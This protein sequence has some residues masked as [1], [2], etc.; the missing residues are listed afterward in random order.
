MD[1][2]LRSILSTVG[3]I[4]SIVQ[5]V[6][7]YNSTNKPYSFIFLAIGIILL[8]LNII[9]FEVNRDYKKRYKKAS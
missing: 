5:I 2:K 1:Y 7:S 8:I 9:N 6:G 4:A 3:I